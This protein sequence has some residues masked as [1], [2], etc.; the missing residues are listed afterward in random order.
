MGFFITL[1]PATGGGPATGPPPCKPSSKS[2]RAR[3][4][5]RGEGVGWGVGA[6]LA[7]LAP[8]RQATARHDLLRGLGAQGLSLVG[9][10]HSPLGPSS[11]R[12]HLTK[13]DQ[14]IQT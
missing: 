14:G 4:A 5:V 12:M 11:G 2:G 10:L 6:F 13:H 9:A 8:A 7:T 1:A 3:W